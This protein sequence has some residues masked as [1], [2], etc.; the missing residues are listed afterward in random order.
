VRSTLEEQLPF[1]HFSHNVRAASITAAAVST[2]AVSA[3][4]V[5]AAAVSA[6]AVSTAA[7]SAAAV[8]TAA[9]STAAVST[10][11]V[12]TATVSAAAVPTPT[13]AAATAA[14][15]T[16]TQQGIRICA[17]RTKR[18]VNMYC[19]TFCSDRCRHRD[20]T[21]RQHILNCILALFPTQ[22][23]PEPGADLL[24]PYLHSWSPLAA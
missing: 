14:H 13:V 10:A 4:A 24:Y 1:E 20:Q 7:V 18:I 12:S 3:A 6:A 15:T 16:G 21:R 17:D 22:F 19:Q 5:S 11:A 8:S 23:L 9:V 2:A